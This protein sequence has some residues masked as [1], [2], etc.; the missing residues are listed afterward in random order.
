VLALQTDDR[1][2]DQRGEQTDRDL[3]SLVRIGQ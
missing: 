1:A 3:R 2:S